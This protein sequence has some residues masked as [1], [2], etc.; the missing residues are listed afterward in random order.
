M[1][2]IFLNYKLK[3]R[4]YFFCSVFFIKL[5]KKFLSIKLTIFFN[6]CKYINI[7][8]S[9]LKVNKNTL[10]L[11]SK[12]FYNRKELVPLRILRYYLYF[13]FKQLIELGV[14][15]IITNKI[16]VYNGKKAKPINIYKGLIEKLVRCNFKFG[17]F[18]FSRHPHIYKKKTKSKTKK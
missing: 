4:N 5:Y 18:I 14:M 12:V 16:N 13:N 8:Y 15:N 9:T 11:K 17:D 2:N 10:L 3:N 6:K 1:N 7:K